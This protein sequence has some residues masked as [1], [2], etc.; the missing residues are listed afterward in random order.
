MEGMLMSETLMVK[1]IFR[2]YKVEFIEDFAEILEDMQFDDTFII[3]DNKV[4]DSYQK[5]VDDILSK[6]QFFSVKSI[7]SNKT[8]N[9]CQNLIENLVEKNIRKNHTIVA[10]GGGI[11]Q[12]IAAFISSIMFRGINWV[13]VPTTLLAQADSCIGSK[14]SI[15]MG[16]Y[17]NLL[18]TF[19]PPS[20]IYIDTKFLETLPIDEIKSGIGEILHFYL[21]AGN[22]LLERLAEEYDELL[23]SPRML[24]DYILE[25]LKIKKSIIEIDEFDRRERNLFNYGHTFGHAIETVSQYKVNHGLAVTMGMDIANYISMN[26]GYL[27]ENDFNYMH[28]ILVKNLP[29]FHLS[30]DLISD[31]FMALSKDK[32]N[33]GNMLGC[34]LCYGPGSMKK[35]QIP[36]DENLKNTIQSYFYSV[37]S[38][39]S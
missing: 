9:Y 22:D 14:T 29:N 26:F 35:M 23:A 2:N 3:I 24:Q 32:K 6:C 7:E 25:S 1:S 18:G 38:K 20:C 28:R 17:K 30:S 16:G 13:V 37:F 27:S 5:Q 19:C 39:I 36:L 10:I 11:I 33:V 15:N 8:L 4:I 34:I 31:Y 21:I 12:D